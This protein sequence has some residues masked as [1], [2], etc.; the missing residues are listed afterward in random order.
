MDSTV[1][2]ER[3]RFIRVWK[4]CTVK[5]LLEVSSAPEC[6]PTP[7]LSTP[8]TETFLDFLVWCALCFGAFSTKRGYLVMSLASSS[9]H[10]GILLSPH[11]HN[12]FW[13]DSTTRSLANG[14]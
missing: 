6:S 10:Y 5:R 7:G 4:Y 8:I 1:D 3:V 13:I 9:R 12:A 14:L 11:H 2:S